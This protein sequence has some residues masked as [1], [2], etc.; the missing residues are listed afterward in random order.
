[1]KNAQI[2]R[3]LST[4]T[5]IS[6]LLFGKLA[7]NKQTEIIAQA[8]AAGKP[9]VFVDSFGKLS[10]TRKLAERLLAGDDMTMELEFNNIKLSDDERD[11]LAKVK[12][13]LERLKALK[14]TKYPWL[15]DADIEAAGRNFNINNRR[16][17]DIYHCGGG[18]YISKGQAKRIWNAYKPFIMEGT[19]PNTRMS[20]RFGYTNRTV[21]FNDDQTVKVGCQ[22]V[23]RADVEYVARH[24]KFDAE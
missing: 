7:A 22:V 15:S 18:E 9:F 16:S 17:D 23:S 2:I 12:P 20:L 5:I 8:Q 6:S 19:K 1:M 10:D 11:G 3:T 14:P 4:G 21:T 24:F 13:L